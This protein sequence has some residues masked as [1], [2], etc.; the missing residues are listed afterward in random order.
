MALRVSAFRPRTR[1]EGP[2]VRAA[3]WLQG[4]TIRCRGC[5]NPHTWARDGGTLWDVEQLYAA[6]LVDHD[7]EGLT[8]LGGEPFEQSGAAAALAER[9]RRDGLGV[10]VFSGY[11][12]DEL[13]HR[14][15]EDA[16]RLLASTDLLVDGP[17]VASR[18]DAARPLVGSTNQRFH[19]LSPRYQAW[20]G[21]LD[22]H[23]DRL[24]VELR[25]DGTVAVSGWAT[26]AGYEDLLTLL[27]ARTAQRRPPQPVGMGLEPQAARQR[28]PRPE[29]PTRTASRSTP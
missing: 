23:P 4:C 24:E 11:T 22:A 19:C 10:I 20:V 6:L 28:R 9:A 8:V 26:T 12:L 16:A 7:V 29:V 27:D 13:R 3:V 17:F 21:A 5:F 14:P 25:R 2:G 15:D 1:A 18:P